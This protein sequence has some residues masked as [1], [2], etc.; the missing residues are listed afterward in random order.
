MKATSAAGKPV[1]KLTEAQATAEL[2]RLAREIAH[3]DELYYAQD[4]P[5][6]SDADYDALRQ[7]NAAIEARFPAL[8]RDDSPSLRVGAAPVAAFGKVRHSVPMLSLG[9]AFSEEDVV[10]F[11]ARVRRFLGLGADAPVELT[12]EPK[13]DGLSISLTYENARL[14]QAATRGDGTEGENVT[15]NVMTMREIPRRLAGKGIPELIEVRGEIYLRHDDFQK[16]NAEQAAAGA[17]VFANPRNAAAGSLRQLDASITA[18]RPLRF[19]AYGWGAAS[20]LPADTQSGVYASF[21][22]WGLPL[23]PLM[24]VCETPE[25][26]LA[27][28]REMEKNR[29]SLGYDIDGVV[30]KVNRLDWQER[31]GFVSRA[32]RWAIAHKFPPQE[33]MT[34]LNDIEIQVGRT[35]ALTPAAKLEPVTVGGVVV[36]NATLHNEDEIARKDIR[37]GDTV[38]VRRAGDVIPQVD[39][40][41]AGQAAQGRQ[42][43]Q[44]PGGLPG[45]R[46]LGRARGRRAHGAHRRGAALHRRLDLSRAG[47]GAAQAFRVAQRLRHRGARREADRAVLRRG[48]D[49]CGRPTS[50]RSPSATRVCPP[51]SGSP[52]RR[53]LGPSRSRTCSRRS[54]RGARSRS[55]ASSMRWASATSARRPRA[56]WPRRWA[57]SRPSARPAWRRPRAARTATPTRS[58]TTSRASA[59]PWSTR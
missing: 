40:H 22:Q 18:R 5:E 2:E 11:I 52:R 17:K 38:I 25:A 35:G 21:Q 37:I 59:P 45:V 29:A 43:L 42:A 58:S 50:S 31:L 41:R 27:F 36:S 6:I 1:D 9:N 34:R 4:A 16:L 46:Q 8:V 28:H 49:H 44:V 51:T 13:I 30:Y 54:R 57:A 15:P 47:Q 23:N 3:H 12:A 33:A 55:T 48:S 39:G 24:R 32:P 26:V 20:T 56:T 53:D 10:D 14:V 19:F 7:R